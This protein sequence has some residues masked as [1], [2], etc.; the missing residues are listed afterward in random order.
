MIINKY[1]YTYK[2]KIII[3]Q[4]KDPPVVEVEAPHVQGGGSQVHIEYW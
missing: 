3:T 4:P 1:K 2:Y